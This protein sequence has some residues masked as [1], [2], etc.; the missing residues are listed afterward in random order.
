MDGDAADDGDEREGDETAA[1]ENGAAEEAG[2]DAGTEAAGKEGPTE[3]C[4]TA[5][6]G[7]GRG[8]GWAMESS[9]RGR[10]VRPWLE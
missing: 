1:D 2:A 3:G 8:G 10:F 4:V 6:F 9:E 7:E 5:F